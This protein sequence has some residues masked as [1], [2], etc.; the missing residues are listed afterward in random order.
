MMLKQN[1]LLSNPIIV[2][3][4]LYPKTV[5]GYTI[6]CAAQPTLK[7]PFTDFDPLLNAKNRKMNASSR[8]KSV[9][10]NNTMPMRNLPG[11]FELISTQL[12]LQHNT[13]GRQMARI[14]PMGTRRIRKGMFAVN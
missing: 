11:V 2:S 4:V 5:V 12:S 6:D 8:K 14:M 9:K 7:I 13:I 1:E 10:P 3:L